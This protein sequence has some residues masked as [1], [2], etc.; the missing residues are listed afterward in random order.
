MPFPAFLPHPLP[1]L[2]NKERGDK[3]QLYQGEE[4]KLN[5]MPFPAF[6]PH[7]Q[8]PLLNKERGDKA[9][10]YRGEVLYF[11]KSIFLNTKSPYLLP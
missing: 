10:L 4:R 1:P 9:Q 11:I 5:N 3:A 6:L 2:L 8:P 7:P